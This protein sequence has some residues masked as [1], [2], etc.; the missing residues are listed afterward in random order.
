MQAA[1]KMSK[2]CKYFHPHASI[3]GL[4]QY[5]RVKKKVLFC[6]D[7]PL[8]KFLYLVATQ[9]YERFKRTLFI[10]TKPV[11]FRGNLYQAT[12]RHLNNSETV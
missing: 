9:T 2:M 5:L 8:A 7:V 4:Y 12:K 6:F 3:H 11:N 1:L 10:L